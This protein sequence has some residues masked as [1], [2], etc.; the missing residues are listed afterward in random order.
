MV[1]DVF[2]CPVWKSMPVYLVYVTTDI[3]VE[4]I[5][6]YAAEWLRIPIPCH[7]FTGTLFVE[8]GV[9]SFAHVR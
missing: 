7:R 8:L 1:Y 3:Q 5:R 4:A 6:L 2:Q 9:F